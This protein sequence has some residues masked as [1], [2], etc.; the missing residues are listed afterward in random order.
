[1]KK[2]SPT[3]SRSHKDSVPVHKLTT[4]KQTKLKIKRNG[5]K[6]YQVKCT[7]NDAPTL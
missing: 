3:N 1:M 6:L 2:A 7:A 4:G 5:I